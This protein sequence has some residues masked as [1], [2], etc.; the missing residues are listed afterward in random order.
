MVRLAKPS[1]LAE[2]SELLTSA[3]L[4]TVGVAEH[5]DTFVVLES[6]GSIVGVGGLE[7][8]ESVALLRSLAVSPTHQRRGL[9]T[10]L[11]DHLEADAASRGVEQLYLLTET[12]A[13]FF[14]KRGYAAISRDDAPPEIASS[15]E[16]SELCPESA[17]FMR[18]AA[19]QGAAADRQRPFPICLL[20]L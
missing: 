17:V 5:L 1:D 9:A 18:R 20:T 4:P 10:T 14:S 7:L 19:Q 3:R 6:G 13:S 2:I 15:E 8:H 16:F 12:A 11:C